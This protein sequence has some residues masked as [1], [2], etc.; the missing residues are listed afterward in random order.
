MVLNMN[1][2]WQERAAREASQAGSEDIV[3]KKEPGTAD[4]EK[5]A[6]AKDEEDRGAAAENSSASAGSDDVPLQL[7]V[8][9]K[10]AAKA[11]KAAAKGAQ[12]KPSQA[13]EATSKPSG[14][15]T[16]ILDPLYSAGYDFRFT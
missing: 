2:V 14:K 12:P 16:A 8:P 1:V 11:T 7:P 6:A 3:V 13:E 9:A 4:L 10:H 15:I 5:S